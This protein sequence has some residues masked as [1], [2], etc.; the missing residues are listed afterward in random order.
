MKT[1]GLQL[2]DLT[3]LERIEQVTSFVGRDSSGSFGVQAGHEFFI[4]CLQPGLARYRDAQDRWHYIAQPGAVLVFDG[5]TLQIATSEYLCSDD[6]E[7]VVAALELQWA[8]QSQL[9]GLTRRTRLQLE[10]NLARKLWD[11]NRRGEAL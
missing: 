7:G 8:E 3:R 10:Q 4:T 5:Q 11:M 9:S 6:R 2:N 1:F